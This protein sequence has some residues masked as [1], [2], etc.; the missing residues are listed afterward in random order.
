MT[1]AVCISR[2]VQQI[3][4]ERAGRAELRMR[5]PASLGQGSE[6]PQRVCFPSPG[7]RSGGGDGGLAARCSCWWAGEIA[8]AANGEATVRSRCESPHTLRSWVDS[9]KVIWGRGYPEAAGH[10]EAPRPALKVVSGRDYPM[11]VCVWVARSVQY[12]VELE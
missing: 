8:R 1:A 4:E 3:P 12:Q 11:I 10:G 7:L 9:A 5:L 6:S 2:S